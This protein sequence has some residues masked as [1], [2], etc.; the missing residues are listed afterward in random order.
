MKRFFS[1]FAALVSAAV[2]TATSALN[3]YAGEAGLYFDSESLF[4]DDQLYYCI[5]EVS[6]NALAEYDYSHDYGV[7]SFIF[8][9][10]GQAAY[11]SI[12][13]S[14][15]AAAA[16]IGQ[17]IGR[18]TGIVMEYTAAYN[19]IVV[20]LTDNE[21]KTVRE[22]MSALGLTCIDATDLYVE[23]YA[24][25]IY[26][27]GLDSGFDIQAREEYTYD[28]LTEDVISSVGVDG[29][30]KGDGT[31]IAVI[32]DSMDIDHEFFTL[33]EGAQTKLTQEY[34]NSVAPFLSAT[35][36]GGSG[37]YYS[38]KVPFAFNYETMSNDVGNSYGFHGTHVAGIA[39]GNGG[40]ETDPNYNARGIAPDAQLLF[41]ADFNLTNMGIMGALDDCMFL[42]ADVINTSFGMAGADKYLQPYKNKAIENLA[43]C[44]IILCTAAGNSGKFD[45]DD[46]ALRTPDYSTGGSQDNVSDSFAV[47]S[48]EN[49]F[50]EIQSIVTGNKKFEITSFLGNDITE[51]FEGQSLE[52]VVIDGIGNAACYE[53]VDV[54]GK[55]AVV[56][57][58]EITFN[59]KATYAKINGAVGI[60]IYNN[61]EGVVDAECDILPGG[62][63]SDEAG[64][65]LAQ[66]G[67]GTLSFDSIIT[68]VYDKDQMSDFSSWDFTEDLVLKPDIT[69]FGG[70]IIS[71]LPGD[72]YSALSGTSMASPQLSGVCAL[73]K[74]Y[75]SAN[76]EKYGITSNSDY[77]EII[78]RL[79]MS[80]A[81]PVYTSDGQQIAS[82]RVQGSGLANLSNAINTP[83]YLYTDS[84]KDNCRPKISMG[85]CPSRSG[86]FEFKFYIRNV[87]DTAQTYTLDADLFSDSADDKYLEWNTR[88]MSE[89]I[90]FLDK[91][92]HE[93]S[94]V[95]VESLSDAEINVKII[96]GFDD[97]DYLDD[98]FPYGTFIDGFVYLR[99]STSCD[100][101]LPFMGFYGDWTEADLFEPF[102]YSG[103]I[104]SCVNS[105]MCD[106]SANTAGLNL[107]ENFDSEGSYIIPAYSPD[108]DGVMDKV[109]IEMYFKRRCY[110]VTAK[111]YN[112]SNLAQGV[113]YQQD[114]GTG[115]KLLDY[116]DDLLS[117]SYTLDWDFRDLDGE[118]H[119]GEMYNL[120]ISATVPGTSKTQV[121][122]QEF[123]VDLSAPVIENCMEMD[124]NGT[125]NILVKVSDSNAL[126]GGIML[127]SESDWYDW[128]A[129]DESPLSQYVLLECESDNFIA[130][131]YDMAGNCTAVTENNL[132]G[133]KY[134][135]NYDEGRM[136]YTTSDKDFKSK[137][138]LTDSS[139]K[140]VY[141][142]INVTPEQVYKRGLDGFDLSIGS[143]VIAHIE[144]QVGLAGDANNDGTVDVF[145]AVYVAQ[146]TVSPSSSKYKGFKDSI[147][148]CLADMKKDES[149][150]VF[151][152]IA[153]AK[154]TVS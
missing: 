67:S 89:N 75:L 9:E 148:F 104:P 124:I 12:K 143:T 78:A 147:N 61:E 117:C 149:V 23:E 26:R 113:V 42:D 154:Y 52:Y 86:E 137:I 31:V 153:I 111:I 118:I 97:M 112:V 19:G 81:E 44:G 84:E 1:A 69:G 49:R 48:A 4:A 88:P 83:S 77:T 105:V 135:L 129:G 116:F 96:I 68:M 56:E 14:H 142:S 70:N 28:D 106:G 94:S 126:Q 16:A 150:D 18:D 145:D 54:K 82:P 45:Y 138:S 74:E 6:G 22:N 34:I 152:A 87:S 102:V 146:Y 15:T 60:I 43:D 64:L 95:T 25:S 73:L 139:G 47:G 108:G 3:A 115:Y 71:S 85:D 37:Y 100:L 39:G 35:S 29:N 128:F 119:D 53:G 121:I 114:L 123:V 144:A 103:R 140:K 122:S 66:T 110:N 32:D 59:E 93:I 21:L 24:D 41:M 99:S 132:S 91:N 72:T 136:F 133:E 57:R 141:Y 10:E 63:I 98:Y 50:A 13:E 11:K 30:L 101:T 2:L 55:V 7:S 27:Y 46:D 36:A 109:C 17:L 130:E 107:I 8:T 131:I 79:I 134:T 65:Y 33:S 5:A 125:R 38:D 92:G 120:I 90:T 76:K 151:D 80:T 62:I 127:D 40:S 20:V 58:G 51:C